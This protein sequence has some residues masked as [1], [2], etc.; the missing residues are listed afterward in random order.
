[1]FWVCQGFKY[2][3]C[4]FIKSSLRVTSWVLP[5]CC[6]WASG[7]TFQESRSKAPPSLCFAF[8]FSAAMTNRS[9]LRNTILCHDFPGSNVCLWPTLE[10]DKLFFKWSYVKLKEILSEGLLLDGKIQVCSPFP[11]DVNKELILEPENLHL[12]NIVKCFNFH[13]NGMI[14][15]EIF[16]WKKNMFCCLTWL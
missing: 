8:G 7:K 12:V 15:W 3:V 1:M 9:S 6:K 2:D 14:Q 11:L 5:C 4:I 13:K 10:E 16:N